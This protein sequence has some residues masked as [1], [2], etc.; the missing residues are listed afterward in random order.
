MH[1]EVSVNRRN[2]LLLP[3]LWGQQGAAAGLQGQLGLRTQCSARLHSA[4]A[5]LGQDGT[6]IDLP[7]LPLQSGEKERNCLLWVPTGP[8]PCFVLSIH[9]TATAGRRAWSMQNQTKPPCSR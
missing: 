3:E 9:G 6:G 4:G 8:Q 7:F 5:R 1:L 2:S